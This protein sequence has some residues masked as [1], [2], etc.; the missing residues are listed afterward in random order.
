MCLEPSRKCFSQ[1]SLPRT[2][3]SFFL[4]EHFWLCFCLSPHGFLLRKTWEGAVAGTPTG[5]GPQ[6]PPT[7]R[8]TDATALT[9]E[10]PTG[11]HLGW[12][13]R[14]PALWPSL[15]C[16]CPCPTHRTRLHLELPFIHSLLHFLHLPVSG[17]SDHCFPRTSRDFPPH[18]QPCFSLDVLHPIPA[19]A[20]EP[21]QGCPGPAHLLRKL[22][23]VAWPSWLCAV[24]GPFRLP[25]PALL[26]H[27]FL[28]VSLSHLALYSPREKTASK[29]ALM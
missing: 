3:V 18:S 12:S 23:Q 24:S 13:Q 26:L 25:D 28:L 4:L 19:P 20:P 7:T 14:G 1:K 21:L 2:V 17:C 27:Y 9:L 29:E 22:P 5:S 6:P 10:G 11:T 16:Q 8:K 15:I